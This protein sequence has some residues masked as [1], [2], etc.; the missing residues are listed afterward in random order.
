[1]QVFGQR[2]K[3]KSFMVIKY[4]GTRSWSVN[5]GDVSSRAGSSS[6]CTVG[7]GEIKCSEREAWKMDG[8]WLVRIWRLTH[9]SS[10]GHGD[11]S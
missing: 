4:A 1:M 10:H 7:E 11:A 2:R 9:S 3:K 6:Y 5:G 8:L